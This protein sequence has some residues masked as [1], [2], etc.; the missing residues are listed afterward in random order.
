[1][2]ITSFGSSNAAGKGSFR[3]SELF[4]SVNNDDKL[5][6]LVL[7]IYNA[8]QILTSIKQRGMYYRGK[9][10]II[11]EKQFNWEQTIYFR[12]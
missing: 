8:S 6:V 2:E 4:G 9:F 12:L 7:R 3:S 11:H 5:H 1:M 10:N